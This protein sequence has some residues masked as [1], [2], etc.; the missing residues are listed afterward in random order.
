M[1]DLKGF[2]TDVKEELRRRAEYV[3]DALDSLLDYLERL[4]ACAEA[5]ELRE[6]REKLKVMIKKAEN[7]VGDSAL[8][9]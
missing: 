6:L 7:K 9:K 2:G 3:M 4:G 8:E 1:M 5:G